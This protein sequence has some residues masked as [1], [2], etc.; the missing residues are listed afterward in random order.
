M[1]DHTPGPWG[2][3]ADEIFSMKTKETVLKTELDGDAGFGAWS[4]LVFSSPENEALILTA[5]K[6]LEF[7]DS[8]VVDMPDT[9]ETNAF[10]HRAVALVAEVRGEL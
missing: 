8:I 4:I 3:G 6:L 10:L 7:I 9:P 5:P 2:L 1:S